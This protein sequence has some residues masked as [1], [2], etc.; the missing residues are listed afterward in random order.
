MVLIDSDF[1]KRQLTLMTREWYM[2]PNGNFRPM[3]GASP[4]SIHLFK[5]GPYRTYKIDAKK[6]GK[7]DRAFLEGNFQTPPQFHL[8]GQQ[9]RC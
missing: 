5:L 3:S 9:K 6:Y 8:V 4:M 7:E 1:A 2:H